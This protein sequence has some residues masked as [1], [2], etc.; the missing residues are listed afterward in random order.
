MSTPELSEA[1]SGEAR[2]GG[3]VLH[4]LRRLRLLCAVFLL[5]PFGVLLLCGLLAAV[6]SSVGWQR[7]PLPAIFLLVY[8]LAGAAS[9][10][11][12]IVALVILRASRC[13]IQKGQTGGERAL[14]H[15]VLALGWLDIF[16]VALWLLLLPLVF[17]SAGG[18]R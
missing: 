9:P 3:T 4:R 16:A 7:H 5:V 10:L 14:R 18:S 1:A 13:A 17:F 12:G 15:Q 8:L 2:T 6:N 11:V